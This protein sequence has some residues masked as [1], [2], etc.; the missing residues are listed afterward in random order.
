[1]F[2]TKMRPM[3]K[4]LLDD[5]APFKAKQEDE[6]FDDFIH[7][8]LQFMLALICDTHFQII[9]DEGLRRDP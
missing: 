9:L 4:V 5:L 6:I 8:L 2:A 3:M 7:Q 1:M